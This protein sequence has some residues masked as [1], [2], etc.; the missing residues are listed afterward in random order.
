[1]SKKQPAPRF[2]VI[3]GTPAPDTPKEQVLKRV[4]AMPKPPFMLQCHRCGG[5]ELIETKLGVLRG[6]GKNF[7]GTKALLCLS[8]LMG[9]ERVVVG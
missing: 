7:K 2:V 4:R 6:N 1:M 8:C 3:E 5:R 9:G